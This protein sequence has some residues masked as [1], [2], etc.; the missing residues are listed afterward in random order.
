MLLESGTNKA[1]L[2]DFGLAKNNRQTV[3]RGVGTPAYMPPEMFSEE[4]D[5][6]KT[7]MLA[8][9]IYAIAVIIWQLWF[10]QVPYG[11][12]GI[13]QTIT[14]VMHG[15]RLS[16]TGATKGK[17]AK[18]ETGADSTAGH[19]AIPKAQSDLI[20]VCWHQEA[21]ERPAIT[22]VY[23]TFKDKVVPAIEALEGH[24]HQ[25][26]RH[27]GGSGACCELEFR[28]DEYGNGHRYVS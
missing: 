15:N 18:A 21:A 24:W 19:P 5:P 22:E 9:D 25:G 1:M 26:C 8:V 3:T 14:H 13:H 23:A 20:E 11:V 10:K 27:L 6:A 16:L 4:D 2:A 17:G 7:N 12:K 28:T